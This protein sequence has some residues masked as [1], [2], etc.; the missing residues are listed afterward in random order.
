VPNAEFA[1]V[2]DA[3]R[4]TMSLDG[5]AS[6]L[7]RGTPLAPDLTTDEYAG[8]QLAVNAR[9]TLDYVAPIVERCAARTVVD[10][11]CGVGT[12]VATFL[13]R[14]YDAYGV[15]VAG[16][17]QRWARLGLPAERFVIVDPM[18]MELP[19]ADESVDFAFSLG[20]I[21][22]VGTSNGHSDRLPDYR[23]RRAAW[24][25]EVFRTLRVGG[26]MLMGG[27]NRNFPVDVAHGLDSRASSWERALSRMAG[28]SIHKT[29][30]ENFLWSYADFPAYLDGL[31][32]RLEPLSVAGYVHYGRVPA[33]VRP[34]VR[35]YV[36][37][38]PRAALGTGLNPWVMALVRRLA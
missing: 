19:F 29:W 11:G 26:H 5:F 13:E 30:G 35:G 14:G 2:I 37:H 3:G 4:V 34:V 6:T 24:L 17:S 21:E 28:A 10:I 25:R 12:M 31:A 20:V 38:M 9:K 7:A 15:D 16:L 32:Y 18:R 8:E 22:H 1:S 33:L 27:P 23:A 36:N